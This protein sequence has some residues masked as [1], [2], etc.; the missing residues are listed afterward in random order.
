MRH[1]TFVIFTAAVL[2]S[3]LVSNHQSGER[4]ERIKKLAVEAC[5]ASSARTAIVAKFA[6]TAAQ[7]RKESGSEGTAFQYDAF[8]N[9]LIAQIPAPAGH[10]FDTSHLLDV[11]V[12]HIAGRIVY[13]PSKEAR[14][15]QR[16]G[17]QR[18]YG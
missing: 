6:Q 11:D 3:F 7:A 9:G 4:D 13:R 1:L 15:M 2:I 10:L 18:K 12:L 14:N 5:I 17:C 8:A 16:L